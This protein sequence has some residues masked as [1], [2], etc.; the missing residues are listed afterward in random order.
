MDGRSSSKWARENLCAPSLNFVALSVAATVRA[1]PTAL[2]N[3]YCKKDYQ[4]EN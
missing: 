1:I 3:S 2:M 4:R